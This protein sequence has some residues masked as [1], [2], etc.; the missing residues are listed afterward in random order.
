LT[1]SLQLAK[2]DA[3]TLHRQ[4][5]GPGDHVRF[6]MFEGS[7]LAAGD[8]TWMLCYGR[9]FLPA[10]LPYVTMSTLFTNVDPLSV[11]QL[12]YVLGKSVVYQT[13][14]S[15]QETVEYYKRKFIS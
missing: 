12:Y 2:D 8:D 11:G 6:G 1:G 3:A 14:L 13:A 15:L 7:L 4:D 5:F 10:S 9:G